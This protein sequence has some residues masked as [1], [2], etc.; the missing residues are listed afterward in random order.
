MRIV[1]C[2]VNLQWKW[3]WKYFSK[4]CA[5]C[6]TPSKKSQTH[7][8]PC[9]ER[10]V[11]KETPDSLESHKSRLNRSSWFSLEANKMTEINV[12]ES[13]NIVVD[14]TSLTNVTFCVEFSL[15]YL[16]MYVVCLSSIH[17]YYHGKYWGRVCVNNDR[18]LK[19]TSCKDKY[20]NLFQLS[21]HIE[22]KMTS[23]NKYSTENETHTSVIPHFE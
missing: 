11:T 19:T 4:Y 5:R 8:H 6:L 2:E 15:A 22:K 20:E 18:V 9:I 10:Y 1:Y 14:R 16:F 12:I 17:F 13:N 23:K 21:C 3:K 7:K